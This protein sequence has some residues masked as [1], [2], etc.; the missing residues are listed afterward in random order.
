MYNNIANLGVHEIDR[1][2]LHRLLNVKTIA[3]VENCDRLV[4]YSFLGLSI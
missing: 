4:E 2:P 3:L 1:R